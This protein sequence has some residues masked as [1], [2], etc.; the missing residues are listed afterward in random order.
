MFS[1]GPCRSNVPAF[2]ELIAASIRCHDV[3]KVDGSHTLFSVAQHCDGVLAA[4]EK[5]G[6]SRARATRR[7]NDV[8][9][10]DHCQEAR[11]FPRSKRSARAFVAR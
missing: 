2:P 11:R 3:A 9:A 5:A 8:G 10:P 6:R 4:G 7:A 1:S